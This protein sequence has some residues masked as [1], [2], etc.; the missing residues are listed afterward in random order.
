MS[1]HEKLI[2]TLEKV[3]M[4]LARARNQMSVC[5]DL[6]E[7]EEGYTWEILQH[8]IVWVDNAC[9]TFRDEVQML[10]KWGA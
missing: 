10:R 1:N 8:W 7:D 9:E 2:S 4:D 5:I 6:C 3:A